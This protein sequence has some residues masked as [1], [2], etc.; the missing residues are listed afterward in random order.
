MLTSCF[1][2][3]LVGAFI[4]LPLALVFDILDGWVARWRKVCSHPLALLSALRRVQKSS[5]YGLDLDS[6]AD[7][8]SFSVAPA[9]LGFTLGLRG[10][11]DCAMLCFFVCCGI[12]RLARWW[13]CTLFVVVT[14]VLVCCW[15]VRYNVTAASLSS[16]SGKVKYYQVRESWVD[17][18]WLRLSD[19]LLPVAQ[20]FPVPTSLVLVV[21][22][23]ALYY[24]SAVFDQLPFGKML[25]PGGGASEKLPG[26]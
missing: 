8:V 1:L 20:G 5:P 25:L 14:C 11:W 2:S 17:M 13:R 3:S 26:P 23:A 16:A 18:P 4:L 9:V 6:L 21:M 19:A 24:N 22:F 10:I 7:V 12:S 15:A